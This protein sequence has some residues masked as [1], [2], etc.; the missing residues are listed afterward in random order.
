MG[1]KNDPNS[2][3]FEGKNKNKNPNHQI[4]MRS[5]SR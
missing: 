3:H 4:F 5:S 2:P 1:E